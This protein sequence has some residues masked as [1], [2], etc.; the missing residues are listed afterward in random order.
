LDFNQL[1]EDCEYNLSL[2]EK[3]DEELMNLKEECNR[4]EKLYNEAKE[5]VT[6]N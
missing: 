4:L 6:V 5:K 3:K 1:N 2:L